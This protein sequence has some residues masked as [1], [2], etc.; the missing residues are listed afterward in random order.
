MKINKI[1]FK[2]KNE[3]DSALR[4]F[5]F[6]SKFNYIYSKENS[7]G[8]ST[9][10]RFLLYALGFSIPNTRKVKFEEFSI[11]TE[12][13][14]GDVIF[15]I[16]REGRKFWVNGIEMVLPNDIMVA[17]SIIF[18]CDSLDLL[19]NILGAIYIDQDRGWTLLN[20]GTI[21]GGIRFYIEVF[22]H[23]LKGKDC[24][25]DTKAALKRVDSELEKYR[26]MKAV[27]EYKEQVIKATGETQIKSG[28]IAFDTHN[29]V[30]EN[31]RRELILQKQSIEK[32]IGFL[33]HTIAD[34]K[35]FIDWIESHNI[36]VKG[37]NGEQI[38][39]TRETIENYTDNTELNKI[40]I[41]RESIRLKSVIEQIAII[42][43]EINE[44]SQ[45]FNGETILDIFENRIS[46]IPIDLIAVEN[47]IKRLTKEQS[48]YREILRNSAWKQNQWAYKLNSLILAYAKELCIDEYLE[49]GDSYLFKDIKSISG[50]IYHK[51]VFVFRLC[52]NRILS[53]ML[54][55][56]VPLFIDSPSGRE[57]E[58][59]AIKD[60][61]T[62]LERDFSD[63]QIFLA[64][65]NDFFKEAP[66]NKRIVMNGKLFD[67]RTGQISVFDI[68]A[69]KKTTDE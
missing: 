26:Q 33:E 65:I 39:V 51:M 17:H 61:I 46:E 57:V 6:V 50:A 60:M 19:E 3:P 2:R 47:T 13:I 34:D 43:K 24:D 68:L 12:I 56:N 58:Q 59:D 67:V 54:Q 44:Q 23:G 32:R 53:E 31:N 35:K 45:L 18:K 63:H 15:P 27:A 62:I 20:R 37:T 69:D 29:E 25:A 36:I 64:S 22:L 28:A 49:S 42:N 66:D 5:D 41:R 16:K 52:Y 8:K 11:Q 55:F 30:L 1:S 4:T 21:I 10:M 38:P 14:N 40:E 7:T 9:L 48:Q